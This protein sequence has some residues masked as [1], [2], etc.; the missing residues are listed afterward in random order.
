MTNHEQ[1]LCFLSRPQLQNYKIKFLKKISQD[2][3]ELNVN[4][5]D[6][7][8]I[9]R[10]IVPMTTEYNIFLSKDIWNRG[11]KTTLTKLKEIK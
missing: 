2:T 8:D 7:T 6:R 10:I 9:L 11:H 3:E 5:M 1:G 4:K